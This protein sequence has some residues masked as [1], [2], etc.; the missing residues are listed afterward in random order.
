MCT[1]ILQNCPPPLLIFFTLTQRSWSKDD[2]LLH[3]FLPIKISVH[4]PQHPL[5][6]SCSSISWSW[7]VAPL[8]LFAPRTIEIRSSS[9]AMT[10]TS[11]TSL[12]GV[13][14][15]RIHAE[16]C[17]SITSENCLSFDWHRNYRSCKFSKISLFHS[18]PF[19]WKCGPSQ[20]VLPVVKVWGWR[21]VDT[22]R[23]V[24]KLVAKIQSL[25]G[26]TKMNRVVS[27]R[28]SDNHTGFKRDQTDPSATVS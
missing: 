15:E 9:L 26:D 8:E 2:D 18:N 14:I 23:E 22:C 21:E 16:T 3:I 25:S 20:G 19:F 5:P 13:F 10:S 6:A 12:R 1:K 28:T 24:V 17:T 7:E 11:S 27:A 4:F